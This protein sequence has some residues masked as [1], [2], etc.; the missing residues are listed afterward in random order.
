LA[1]HPAYQRQGIGRRLVEWDLEQATRDKTP[2]GLEASAKGTHLYHSL[3]FQT[4][5]VMPLVEEITLTAMVWRP[6]S[7]TI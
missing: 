1:V 7:L 6:Y 4:V 3:G 2:V 5:N